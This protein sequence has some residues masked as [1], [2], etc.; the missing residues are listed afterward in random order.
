MVNEG[1]K[2]P[3]F[4]LVGSDGKKHAM[5]DFKGKYLVLYFYPKDDTPGCTTEA[6]DFNAS[7][8]EIKELGAEVVGISKDSPESHVKFCSKY[9]LD[10][11]LL[12]DPESS[13]IKA[14][15]AYGDRGVFGKGTLRK[16]Y[17]IDKNG[18]VVKVFP[19]VKPGGHD[20]EVIEFLKSA[21]K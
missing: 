6:K 18:I 2:A 17:I 20:K 15:G 16:T 3:D 19:K 8:K 13:A 1:E 7:R 11:I 4:L 9:S 10:F 14:Y 12:S 21:G 5:K